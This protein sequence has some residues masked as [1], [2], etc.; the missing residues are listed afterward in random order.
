A[1]KG[2]K[3]LVITAQDTTLYGTDLY[4]EPK[5]VELLSELEK[6]DDLKWIRLFYLHPAHISSNLIDKIASSNKILNYFEIP[7]QHINDDIL[8]SMNRKVTR[9]SIE[10]IIT[11]IRSKIPDAVIR[12]TFIVGY[13]GENEKKF[14]EL[15]EFIL[16]Q[17]FEKVGIFSYSREE[18]TASYKLTDQVDIEEAE[19]RKD[20]LMS[21][22]QQISSQNLAKFVG[23]K[24]EVIIDEK[25]E[26]DNFLF[27]GRTYMDGPEID[28]KVLI[29]EGYTNIGDIVEVEIIDNWEYDL[30]GRIVR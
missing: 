10:E 20:E 8:E 27:E 7:F 30:I 15:K 5:L 18:G 16:A 6:I 11:E 19:A 2:V 9:K 12:T 21:I 25:A 4:E 23:K 14:Q 26:D 13:P 28:G 3:E 22:Q 29:T 1:L 24:L 17:H